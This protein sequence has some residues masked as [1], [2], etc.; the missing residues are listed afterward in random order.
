ML[1]SSQSACLRRFQKLFNREIPHGAKC[2]ENCEYSQA[3]PESRIKVRRV[4]KA[5]EL[6]DEPGD[7]STLED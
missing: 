7:I 5:K 1:E 6:G 3:A 2:R 4:L